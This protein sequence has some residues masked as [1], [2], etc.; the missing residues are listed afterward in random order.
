MRNKQL[1]ST[2]PL[3]GSANAST[4]CAALN[5]SASYIYDHMISVTG[6][7]FSSWA[8]SADAITYAK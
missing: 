6:A 2:F 4:T 3:G 7:L 5:I 8:G 1:N